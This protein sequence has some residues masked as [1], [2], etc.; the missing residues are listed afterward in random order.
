M[1]QTQGRRRAPILILIV[2]VMVWAAFGVISN[3]LE[4]NIKTM[5]EDDAVAVLG[6]KVEV[7]DVA[8]HLISGRVA[9][10]GLK[11]ANSAGF[12]SPTLFDMKRIEADMGMLSLLPGMLGW[13]PYRLEEIHI[14]SPVVSVDVDDNG[15]TNLDVVLENI[16]RSQQ[17][18]AK[19]KQK[20][21]PVESSTMPAKK[22]NEGTGSSRKG[23]GLDRELSRLTIDQLNIE[24]LSYILRR[25]GKPDKSGTLPDIEMQNVGGK[26][27]ATV[28]GIGLKVSTRLAGDILSAVLLEQAMDK[29]NGSASGLLKMLQ[30]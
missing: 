1:N 16:Q 23:K 28:A 18:A 10:S 3:R 27:G 26:K 24:G 9:I 29:L 30:K 14:Q 22:S 7:E 6:L 4:A 21:T 8:V 19:A 20:R 5:L 13:K 15:R 12:A 17:D 2:I 11:V 25:E